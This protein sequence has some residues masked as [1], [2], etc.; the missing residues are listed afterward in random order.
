MATMVTIPCLSQVSC[1]RAAEPNPKLLLGPNSPWANI[2]NGLTS[3]RS[4]D[5]TA[6]STSFL[7]YMFFPRIKHGKSAIEAVEY[8]AGSSE[9]IVCI[10]SFGSPLNELTP[11]AR[12]VVGSVLI[13]I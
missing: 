6:G 2:P 7:P 5:I 3:G 11:M 12:L 8:C 10:P 4:S 1:G 9:R 13:T